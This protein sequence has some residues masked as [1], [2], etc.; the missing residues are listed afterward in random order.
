[1]PA[2]AKEVLLHGQ[3]YDHPADEAGKLT[4]FF[5]LAEITI[6]IHA[7]AYSTL[8]LKHHHCTG[9]GK[10][11]CIPRWRIGSWMKWL[12]SLH[13]KMWL[14]VMEMLLLNVD[15]SGKR[16]WLACTFFL[17]FLQM[18]DVIIFFELRTI[19]HKTVKPTCLC[20][21]GA[22]KL[23]SCPFPSA[24]FLAPNGQR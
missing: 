15:V 21:L 18:S 17:H 1:M 2:I 19:Q 13:S 3:G 22:R 24:S 5:S 14:S 20:P 16:G 6:F 11:K 12:S 7:H 23:V 10:Q 9:I 4:E 8:C